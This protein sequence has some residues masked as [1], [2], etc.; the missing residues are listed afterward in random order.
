[1]AKHVS[2][3]QRIARDLLSLEV[4]TIVKSTMTAAKTPE[5][6]RETLHQIAKEYRKE[7]RETVLVYQMFEEYAPEPEG[8]DS[9]VPPEMIWKFSGIYSFKELYQ[10]ATLAQKWL[11][12]LPLETPAKRKHATMLAR[13][14]SNS[15]RI[16]GIFEKAYAERKE[17]LAPEARKNSELQNDEK[18]ADR[19]FYSD[20]MPADVIWNN[21]IPIRKMNNLADLELD[22]NQEL[23]LK[24]VWDIGTEEILMQTIVEI[25]GDI[26]TRIQERFSQDPNQQVLDLHANAVQTSIGFWGQ[27]TQLLANVG[28]SAFERLLGRK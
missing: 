19:R 2:P 20:D 7:L 24:K 17:G 14:S 8:E 10:H 9:L 26:T 15:F 28:Q 13:I 25:D 18:E 23:A 4:N 22:V 5:S 27:L 11:K 21:D 3:I 12:R 1:M 16:I 6:L